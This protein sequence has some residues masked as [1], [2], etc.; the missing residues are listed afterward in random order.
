MDETIKTKL[1]VTS[2]SISPPKTKVIYRAA[3]IEEEPKSV[4]EVETMEIKALGNWNSEMG[5]TKYP[6]SLHLTAYPG[7]GVIPVIGDDIEITL[8]RPA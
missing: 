3:T 8:T 2:C 1:R 5:G 6:V 7:C 4:D